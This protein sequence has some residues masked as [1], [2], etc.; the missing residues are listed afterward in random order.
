MPASPDLWPAL[1]LP[2]PPAPCLPSPAPRLRLPDLAC[3]PPP[4][5]T[6]RLIRKKELQRR[7][8]GSRPASTAAPPRPGGLEGLMTGAACP[9]VSGVHPSISVGRPWVVVLQLFVPLSHAASPPVNNL[10]TPCPHPVHTLPSSRPQL[11]HTLPTS[12]PHPVHAL[13]TSCPHPA[14][15][16]P[17]PCPHP[18]HRRLVRLLPLL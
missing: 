12:C 11:V 8:R 3:S 13:S 15:T 1:S 18:V 17:T 10:F 16:L 9:S 7:L 14:R 5:C 6:H 2:A 4:A